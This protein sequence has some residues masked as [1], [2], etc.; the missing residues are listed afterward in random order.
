MLGI[1]LSRI[2]GKPLAEVLSERIF[3]PLGMPDTGFSVGPTGRQRAAT[4]YQLGEGDTLRHDSMG[5][6]PIADPPLCSGGAGL[7][8]TADDYLR[9]V[10]MLL[11]GRNARRRACAV[12]R[13]RPADAHRPADRSA[14]AVSLP[15]D[16]VLGRPRASA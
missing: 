15:G 11:G 14:A 6:A 5:P 8:S 4:M 7:W 12:R 3:G 1:A 16:A 13:V 10:R 2:E 9:F